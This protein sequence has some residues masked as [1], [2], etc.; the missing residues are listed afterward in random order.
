MNKQER[1]LTKERFEQLVK[2]EAGLN[3]Y[4]RQVIVECMDN[5]CLLTQLKNCM[6]NTSIPRDDVPSTY[7]AALRYLYL[8]ELIKRLKE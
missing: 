7:D 1:C 6:Q 5:E 2:S 8:P 4:E 3:S